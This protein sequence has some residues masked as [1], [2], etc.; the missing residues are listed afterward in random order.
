MWN[1]QQYATFCHVWLFG[2]STT[3]IQLYS[4]GMEKKMLSDSSMKSKWLSTFLF[5]WS[6]LAQNYSK[7]LR[8]RRHRCDDGEKKSANVFIRNRKSI[9]REQRPNKKVHRSKCHWIKMTVHRKRFD[10]WAK[11]ARGHQLMNDPSTVCVGAS[12]RLILT[13]NANSLSRYLANYN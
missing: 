9:L 1:G 8:C 5:T 10:V 3:M 13:I 12:G 6:H 11:R 7:S 4:L 2:S